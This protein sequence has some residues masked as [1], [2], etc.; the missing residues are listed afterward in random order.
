[1]YDFACMSRAVELQHTLQ[2]SSC[3]LCGVMKDAA[4]SNDII[5]H[6]IVIIPDE[7]PRDLPRD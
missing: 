5:S 4:R 1:M 6:L 3:T 2:T 7:V